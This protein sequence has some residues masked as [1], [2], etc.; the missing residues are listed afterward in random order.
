MNRT[1]RVSIGF[2]YYPDED[3]LMLEQCVDENEL[4]Q[5]CKTLYVEDIESYVKYNE[6]Y[7]VVNV[8]VIH[9]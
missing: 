5:H 1:I 7:D 9:N 3:E 2:D 8:E 4:I 6:L